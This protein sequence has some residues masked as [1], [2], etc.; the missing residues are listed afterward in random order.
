MLSTAMMAEQQRNQQQLAMNRISTMS[1]AGNLEDM[2]AV[3]IV[4]DPSLAYELAK[5]AS[6]SSSTSNQTDEKNDSFESFDEKAGPFADPIEDE[7]RDRATLAEMQQRYAASNDDLQHMRMASAT[8]MTPDDALQRYA[9]A[10]AAPA[11][12]QQQPS[13]ENTRFSR[14]KG[15]IRSFSRTMS[16]SQSGH[17]VSIE[18][19]QTPPM[20]PVSVSPKLEPATSDKALPR[21]PTSSTLARLAEEEE[22]Q[23]EKQRKALSAMSFAASPPSSGRRQSQYDDEARHPHNKVGKDE[24]GMAM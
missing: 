23:L 15:M 13:Q 5:S 24:F 12:P 16:P 17:S 8:S 11:S 3:K 2:T 1:A 10:I 21:F 22:R 7:A 19:Y 14:F 20:S 9:A 18:N 6:S 4:R